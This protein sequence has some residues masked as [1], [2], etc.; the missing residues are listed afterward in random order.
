MGPV[1]ITIKFSR[2][3]VYISDTKFD[4]Y[5]VSCFGDGACRLLDNL[6]LCVCVVDYAQRTH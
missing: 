2:F 6:P 5:M 4:H 3:L 1:G